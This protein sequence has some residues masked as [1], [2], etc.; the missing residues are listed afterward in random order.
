MLVS[1]ISCAFLVVVS[2][3][4]LKFTH[5]LFP[6]SFPSGVTLGGGSRG[7]AQYNS[8]CVG[9]Q[10]ASIR[11]RL[12][13]LVVSSVY[14][15]CN[16]CCDLRLVDTETLLIPSILIHRDNNELYL[17]SIHNHMHTAHACLHKL[18]KLTRNV[19]LC[20][21]SDL[22]YGTFPF[23]FCNRPSL[24]RVGRSQVYSSSMKRSSHQE[25]IAPWHAWIMNLA[26]E[27]A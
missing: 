26:R 22:T 6:F 3:M 25:C 19:H 11:L 13:S 20:L 16:I 15:Q 23:G 4:S 24:W 7:L 8:I 18:S 17:D 9:L 12:R 27:C 5:N 2:P 10:Y 14:W 1:S 21:Y